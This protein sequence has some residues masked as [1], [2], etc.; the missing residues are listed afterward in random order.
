MGLRNPS[1]K[2]STRHVQGNGEHSDIFRPSVQYLIVDK[3]AN[4][5]LSYSAHSYAPY[6]GVR[7]ANLLLPPRSTPSSHAPPHLPP[8]CPTTKLLH[9]RI[10]A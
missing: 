1:P 8:D 4:Y 3:H 10:C 6:S 7:A 5:V 9:S 2:P